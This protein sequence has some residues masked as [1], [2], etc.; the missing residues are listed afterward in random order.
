MNLLWRGVQHGSLAHDRTLR[1]IGRNRSTLARRKLGQ[2]DSS[3]QGW[4]TPSRKQCSFPEE[5]AWGHAS[6]WALRGSIL[7]RGNSLSGTIARRNG[8]I[9]P[10]QGVNFP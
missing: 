5:K 3:G 7:R 10:I 8:R 6:H 4:G 1:A 9:E 2:V